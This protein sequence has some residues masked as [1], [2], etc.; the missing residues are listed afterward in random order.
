MVKRVDLA[1]YDV[2]KSVVDGTLEGGVRSFGI[3]DGG[4]GT[5]EFTY[6]KDIIPASVL[7][8]IE[9]ARAKIISGEIK[10]S[11]PLQ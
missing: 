10:V 9:D 1:V 7:A 6:T 4:V 11:N 3:E 2:I 5:S 8:A